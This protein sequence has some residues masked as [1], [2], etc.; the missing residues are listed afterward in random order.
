MG[1]RHWRCVVD[2]CVRGELQ[3][4]QCFDYLGRCVGMFIGQVLK[5]AWRISMLIFDLFYSTLFLRYLGATSRQERRINAHAACFNVV[6]E[7]R[8]RGNVMNKSE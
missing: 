8:K 5:L 4:R 7:G 2:G 6:C 3:F 1:E